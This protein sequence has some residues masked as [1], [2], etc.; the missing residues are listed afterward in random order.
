VNEVRKQ[1]KA[2]SIMPGQLALPTR[3]TI[4][5]CG[6]ETGLQSGKENSKKPDSHLTNT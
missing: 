6:A 1:E 4:S 3:E 5:D 2:S